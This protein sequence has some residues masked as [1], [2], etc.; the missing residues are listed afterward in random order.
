M[1][2]RS[3]G[4]AFTLAAGAVLAG[5][6]LTAGPATAASSPIAACGGGSYHEV[7]HYDLADAATI[8]L[9][10][11]GSTDCVVT[12]KTKYVGVKTWTGASI[13]RESDGKVVN[14][15]G[16]YAYY[17]GPVKMSAPGVCIRWGGEATAGDGDILDY[18]SKYEHCG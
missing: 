2:I 18:Q 16:D 17:A 5:S 11:N 4:A 13:Q 9:L 1:R 14:D 6:L 10:Y 7:D 15:S 12:W 3:R 8:Y